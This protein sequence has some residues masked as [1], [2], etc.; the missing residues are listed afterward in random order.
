MPRKLE[1]TMSYE[2]TCAEVFTMMTDEAYVGLKI[3]GTGGSDPDIEVSHVG[4]DVI[5][6]AGRTLPAQVPAIAKKITGDTIRVHETARWSPADE[7]GAR[8]AAVELIFERTP[9]KAVGTLNLHPVGDTGCVVEVDFTVKAPVPL[10]G[11]KLEDV[12][13]HQMTRAVRQENKIGVQWLIDHGITPA[14]EA[15]DA[16]GATGATGATP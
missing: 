11:G 1:Y 6:V 10:I 9:G 14:P 7:F 8:T 16:T 3:T 5:V 15:P 13:T 12:I 2:T 4:S